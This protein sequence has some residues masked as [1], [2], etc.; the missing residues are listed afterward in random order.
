MYVKPGPVER[1]RERVFSRALLVGPCLPPSPQ[2]AQIEHNSMGLLWYCRCARAYLHSVFIRRSDKPPV[3]IVNAIGPSMEKFRSLGKIRV[4]RAPRRL[5][6]N[7]WLFV[8][9]TLVAT[10]VG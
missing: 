1:P 3:P 10:L 4:A 9:V 5:V 8:L 7:T 2:W 6:V